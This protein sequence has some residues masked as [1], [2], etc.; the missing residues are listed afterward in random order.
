MSEQPSYYA[1]IPA[2]VRYDKRISPNAKLLFGELTA[3]SNKK[4][5]CY[6]GNEYFAQLYDVHKKTIQ[7]WI[8]DLAGAGFILIEIEDDSVHG[9]K[10]KIYIIEATEQKDSQGGSKI[11]PTPTEQNHSESGSEI[12]PGTESKHA[13]GGS[14]KLTK[15]DAQLPV[16][17]NENKELSESER[18]RIVQLNTT[19]NNNNND[20]FSDLSMVLKQHWGKAGNIG[21][22]VLTTVIDLG[23]KYGRDK[24]YEAIKIVGEK[25]PEKR[26]VGYL[27]G[28]LEKRSTNG[29]STIGST[30][31]ESDSL[32]WS[33]QCSCGGVIDGRV[34][35]LNKQRDWK[36]SKN[37]ERTYTSDAIKKRRSKDARSD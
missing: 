20:D 33:F 34:G 1:I 6:A 17:P 18:S 31:A 10:R 4:G 5:F 3:L 14:E 36:C 2:N 13:E 7:Q 25:P 30:V 9:K 12:T 19:E 27:K 37:C 35:E 16:K 26:G 24:L 8:S 32:I 15:N 21:Y 22:A 23:K 28:V 29:G 11:T